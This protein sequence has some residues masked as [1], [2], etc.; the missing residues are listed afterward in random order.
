MEPSADLIKAV[1]QVK[2][3]NEYRPFKIICGEDTAEWYDGKSGF[4]ILNGEIIQT[5]Q[6]LMKYAHRPEHRK[7]QEETLTP[8]D[9]ALWDELFVL[10]Y[11][12]HSDQEA[13]DIL[14]EET[15]ISE[16]QMK[17]HLENMIHWDGMEYYPYM[18]NGVKREILDPAISFHP[19]TAGSSLKEAQAAAE[20]LYRI[21]KDGCHFCNQER[22][23]QATTEAIALLTEEEQG[24]LKENL[25]GLIALIDDTFVDCPEIAGIYIDAGADYYVWRALQ[26][27]KADEDWARV[28]TALAAMLNPA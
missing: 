26:V 11:E 20:I 5:P 6:A 15:G 7:W 12:G 28:K 8:E 18:A 16:E 1:F 2:G 3:I 4:C 14:V 25:P 13:V 17:S 9:L 21:T 24:W 27:E 10:R 22:M 23:N 19:G